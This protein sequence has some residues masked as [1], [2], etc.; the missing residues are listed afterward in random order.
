MNI[1]ENI[2]KILIALLRKWK[3]IV[4]FA[5]IGGLIGFFYT[6]N[7]TKQ[8]YTSTIEF[9]AYATDTDGEFREI[10]PSTN[11]SAQ[12]RTSNTSKMNYAMKMLDTY[13]EIMGTNEFTAQVAQ[14]LNDRIA[15]SYT[16]S[17]IKNAMTIQGIENTAMFKITV[18]TESADL[19]YEIAH[20]LETT[21]PKMMSKTNN[22]L[23]S[24]SVEDKPVKASAAG[25]L[26]YAKKCT[27]AA[28]IGVVVAAAYIILRNMLDVRVHSSE[29]LIEKY[30][31]PVLGNIP[32]FEIKASHNEKADSSTYAVKGDE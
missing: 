31:I 20:Q 23:V 10:T 3:V 8:T 7:F 29:E 15:S 25:S 17:T 1:D 32:S 2:R 22:G 18:T 6:A 13:I 21:V 9:L 19:S 5:L 26:G 30:D 14:D 12:E 24:A 4:I 28:L 11:T 16:G 27:I